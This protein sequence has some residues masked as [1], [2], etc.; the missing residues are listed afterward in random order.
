[1]TPDSGTPAVTDKRLSSASHMRLRLLIKILM[2]VQA[3]IV[4][5]PVSLLYLVGATIW[6]GLYIPAEQASLARNAGRETWQHFFPLGND[7]LAVPSILGTSGFLLAFGVGLFAVWFFLGAGF[8]GK[9]L[10]EM[11]RSMW[12]AM[13]IGWLAAIPLLL[14]LPS[15]GME[16]IATTFLECSLSFRM[17]FGHSPMLASLAIIAWLHWLGQP[18][19]D[20]ASAP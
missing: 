5:V 6:F 15:L 9:T 19:H 2:G 18:L 20:K 13:V 14:P 11:P 7:V 3:V 8:M 16:T 4:L 17:W 12:V 10:S 1:M